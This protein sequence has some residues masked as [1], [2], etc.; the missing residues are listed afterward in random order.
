MVDHLLGHKTL[1]LF[2]IGLPSPLEMPGNIGLGDFDP[3]VVF[4]DSALE[5]VY[6]AR[7]WS[8]ESK[9]KVLGATLRDRE[10]RSFSM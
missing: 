1:D 9:E 4:E 10:G 5:R 8:E 7:K 2:V 6:A 3:A